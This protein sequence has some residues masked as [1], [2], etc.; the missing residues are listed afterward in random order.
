MPLNLSTEINKV[1]GSLERERDRPLLLK[2][3]S[4][5]YNSTL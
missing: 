1:S 3:I 4:S 2:V 5:P